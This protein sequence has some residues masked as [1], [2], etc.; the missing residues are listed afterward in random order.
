MDGQIQRSLYGEGR[1]TLVARGKLCIHPS[2]QREQLATLWEKK[3]G[4]TPFGHGAIVR[5]A[6]AH[7]YFLQRRGRPDRRLAAATAVSL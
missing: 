4:N 6:R 5:C 7:L 1:R 3:Q 2:W